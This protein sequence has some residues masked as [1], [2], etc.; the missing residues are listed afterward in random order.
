MPIEKHLLLNF[1]AAFLLV[2]KNHISCRPEDDKVEFYVHLI[3]MQHKNVVTVCETDHT[4]TCTLNLK[5][6][7]SFSAHY[8]LKKEEFSID[9]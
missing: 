2:W 4:C 1:P 8:I 3:G 6:T 5:T 9:I 7:L